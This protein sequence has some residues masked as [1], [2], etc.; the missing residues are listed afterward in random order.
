[1]IG[2]VPD[3]SALASKMTAVSTRRVVSGSEEEAP[4]GCTVAEQPKRSAGRAAARKMIVA[5]A[6]FI[7]A[8]GLTN[9]A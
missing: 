7:V 2:N 9:R 1:M 4:L 8:G 3:D 5:S 6:V